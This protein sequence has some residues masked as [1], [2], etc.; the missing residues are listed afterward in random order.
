MPYRKEGAIKSR[1][2]RAVLL[3]KGQIP[4][5][6]GSIVIHQGGIYGEVVESLLSDYRVT[7]DEAGRMVKIIKYVFLSFLTGPENHLTHS[8][9][10]DLHPLL[11][12]CYFSRSQ[13]GSKG[14]Y[15]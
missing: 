2:G 1:Q 15:F 12:R 9:K 3:K 13:V 6:R 4:A 8:L 14:L 7:R 10:I 5:E 11:C